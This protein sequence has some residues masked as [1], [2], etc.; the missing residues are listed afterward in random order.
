MGKQ[1]P[2]APF[3]IYLVDMSYF[4]GKMEAYLRY[5]E[6]PF[7]RVEATDRIL[8][9]QVYENT[10]MMK[11]PVIKTADNQWLK[12]TT[13]MIAWFEQQYPDNPIYPSDAA[14]R[15][16]AL[17]LEDYADEWLWRPALYYRWAFPET[18]R[19]MANRIGHEVLSEWPAP[20]GIA[21]WYFGKRQQRLYL[22]GDGV[23]D[24]NAAHIEQLYLDQLT[25]LE[26]I[27]QDTPY[28]LGNR[29]TIADIGYFGPM[30]RHFALDPAPAKIMRDNAPAVYEWVARMWNAKASRFTAPLTT[31]DFSHPGWQTILADICQVYLPYLHKNASAWQE[32]RQHYTFKADGIEYPNLTTVQYRVYCREALQ[33]AYAALN[34]KAQKTV[35]NWLATAG[36]LDALHADGVIDSGL[37]DEQQLPLQPRQKKIGR[38]ERLTVRLTG[39]PWDLP[40]PFQTQSA[41]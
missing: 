18:H 1:N 30:F 38:I 25:S 34:A 24:E 10:G 28:L 16:M 3:T 21:G 41:K 6:I 11:V 22:K 19:L 4:S 20:P 12:D 14:T 23:T 40:R 37:Q 29:P 9:E 17:L 15:F 39:T 8:L 32:G 7:E 35:N 13:P 5:K 2:H 31:T 33:N 26:A 36:G 27:L